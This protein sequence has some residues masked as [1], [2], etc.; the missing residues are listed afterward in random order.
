MSVRPLGHR[1]L[2]KPDE[3][4]SES[5]G[6]L[7]LPQDHDH[8]P[9]SG[10]VVALGPGGSQ[11]RY[12]ARQA[13]IKDCCEVLESA[14]RMFGSTSALLVARDE[15]AG[16]LGTTDVEREIRIGD[17]VAYAAES[18]LLFTQDGEQFIIL[19]ED[20]VV[21]VVEDAEVAA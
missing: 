18:G 13:A 12:R 14:I 19:N 2:V 4:P 1:V 10:T 9:M 20:D 17:R 3:Q 7:I 6:G 11:V 15:V 16:L 21:V 5:A 8:V